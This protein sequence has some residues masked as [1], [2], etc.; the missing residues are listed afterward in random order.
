MQYIAD[1]GVLVMFDIIWILFM[2]LVVLLL[3][4]INSVKKSGD[5]GLRESLQANK[6]EYFS[7]KG[8]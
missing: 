8:I 7:G 5:S 4:L 2:V 1:T 6:V 3:I